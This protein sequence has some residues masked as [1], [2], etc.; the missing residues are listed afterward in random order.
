MLEIYGTEGSFAAGHGEMH[1][2]TRKL[3]DE[4]KAKYIADALVA[5]PSPMQQWINAILRDEPMT[6]TIQ[7]GR[8]LTELM[9]AFYMSSEQGKAIEFPL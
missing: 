2:Q 9:Q 1:F 3:S 5:P 7:D 4:E 8:N 6:I